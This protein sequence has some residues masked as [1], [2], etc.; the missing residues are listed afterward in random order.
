MS[1]ENSFPVDRR[2][3]LGAAAAGAGLFAPSNVLAQS[4]DAERIRAAIAAGH[5][6]AIERLQE[7]IRNPT[8]AAEGRNV[9]GGADHM[10]QLAQEAGFKRVEKV[11]TA[12]VPGVF[13]TLDAGAKRTLGLYFMYD[14]KQF[15]PA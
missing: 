13:A 4:S 2:T 10:M 6:A 14:V 7:W 3:L 1:H 9:E 12:G 5:D 8:V 11:P 15:D